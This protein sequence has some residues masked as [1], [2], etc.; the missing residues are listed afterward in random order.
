[1]PFRQAHALV[2]GAGP[3]VARAPRAPGGA[4]PG[5]P[6]PGRGG[7]PPARARGGGH[8]ADHPGRGRPGPGGRAS[9]HRFTAAPRGSTGPG[10]PCSE[11]PGKAGPGRPTPAE[12]GGRAPANPGPASQ[13]GDPA[14]AV[15]RRRYAGDPLAVAPALLG[16]AAGPGARVGRIVEVEAYR[17]SDDPASHAYRGRTARNAAMFG[18]P[19][20]PLRVLHLRHALVRQRRL[21]SRGPGRAVLVRALAP[22]TGARG[23]ALGPPGRAPG[24][25]WPADRRAATCAGARPSC[26]RPWGSTG[27]LRRGRPGHRGPG[28]PACSTTGWPRP[29]VPGA[30]PRV[31][32]RRA[33]RAAL[34][35]LG[36]REPDVSSGAPGRLGWAGAHGRGPPGS[37]PAGVRHRRSR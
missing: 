31:G 34:A 17:G 12:P 4:G 20:L 29:G 2:G 36:A 28:P 1:M 23:D 22:V 25:R 32:M 18:P 19:G 6:R 27:E 5:P 10:W 14:R 26:A 21:R 3:R 9:S 11:L 7:G 37:D 13:P 30:G 15:P 24:G 16:Q 35:V 8:P 33:R